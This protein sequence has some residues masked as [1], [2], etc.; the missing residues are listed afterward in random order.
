M[1][2]TMSALRAIPGPVALE[3]AKERADDVQMLDGLRS[4]AA[5]RT[6]R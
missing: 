3:M 4:L 5:S 1:S 6:R 2:M